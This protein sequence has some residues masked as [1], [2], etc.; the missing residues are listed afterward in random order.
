[1]TG[2]ERSENW[3]S[4]DFQH[5]E[6]KKFTSIPIRLMSFGKYPHFSADEKKEF[7]RI[8]CEE[9]RRASR[10][11]PPDSI[12]TLGLIFIAPVLYNHVRYI[13]EIPILIYVEDILRITIDKFDIY[14][15]RKEPSPQDD[16]PKPPGP[17]KPRGRRRAPK[18]APLSPAVSEVW[19]N[20]ALTIGDKAMDAS[21]NI[22][23]SLIVER[24]AMNATTA[25]ADTAAADD[26]WTRLQLDAYDPAWSLWF[27][28]FVA[29]LDRNLGARKGIARHAAACDAPT[30]CGSNNSGGDER[31]W[32]LWFW[33][34]ADEDRNLGARRGVAR[35]AVGCE[36]PRLWYSNTSHACELVSSL[37]FW[38]L[39]DED[40]SLGMDG[41]TVLR[42]A[43]WE[44]LPAYNYRWRF[45]DAPGA[46]MPNSLTR[47]T[48]TADK[49][50]NHDYLGM[51]QTIH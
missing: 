31:A 37:R 8:L 51:S 6:P 39:A 22:S 50:R 12:A 35:H 18:M 3:P 27:W 16:P 34:F 28:G 45:E 36:A 14:L 11:G 15:P 4:M 29:D 10:V 7:L 26:P 5:L 33:E 9:S 40:G 25:F 46:V 24:G 47:F 48:V 49:R 21:I 1:M 43:A 44:T 42:A 38:E 32:S 2:L 30:L 41:S 19:I 13:G 20:V 23:T 17:D